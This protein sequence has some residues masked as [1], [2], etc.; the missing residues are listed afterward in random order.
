[1]D[2]L[3]DC[4]E[5]VVRVAG[6]AERARRQDRQKRTQALAAG[7]DDVFGNLVDQDDV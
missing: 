5:D 3:D 2:E 7:G 1:V 6:I 4:G